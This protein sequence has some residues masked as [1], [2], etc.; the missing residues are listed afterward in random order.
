MRLSAAAC[1]LVAVAAPTLVGVE[2]SF[3]HLRELDDRIRIAAA[4]GLDRLDGQPLSG[5][6][7][8]L[9][10]EKSAEARDLSLLPSSPPDSED[11]RAV[12]TM[13]RA[14]DQ[15]GASDAAAAAPCTEVAAAGRPFEKL[16]AILYACFGAAA[17]AIEVR[18]ERLDRLTALD[19]LAREESPAR[20]KELFLAMEPLYR[21]VNG[22]DGAATSPYRSLIRLSAARWRTGDSPVERSLRA[23]RV[24]SESLEP[25]L[26]SI[27]AAWRDATPAAPIE[28]WDL[29]YAT[30]AADRALASRIPLDR[31]RSISDRFYAA[32]G[33]GPEALG[34]HY[35]LG[36][37]PG[38]T[39]VAFTD[40]GGRPQLRNGRWTTGEPWVF[41]T[42]RTGGLGNL[43][44][45]LHETGHAIHIAAIRTRPAFADWP[46]SDTFTEALADL[47]ALEAFEPEWQ[48]RY[49]GAEAPVAAS[50][51]SKYGGIVLDVAWALFELRLHRDPAADPNAV[52]T[53][54][55]ERYLHVV[56][57]PEISWWARRG[58]LVDSP[59]YMVN[60]ALGAIIVADLRARCRALRGPFSAEDHGY[61]SWLSEKI[62]RYGLERASGGVLREF[63][64]RDMSPE[65]LIA[66]LGRARENLVP[67]PEAP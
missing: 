41:A 4:R 52:W 15:I 50:L 25:W 46:D 58:Q 19:R 47:A 36:P 22:D 21:A 29:A 39:P 37:R 9:S 6:R 51:R 45:L 28:P 55:T 42:Y 14:F 56:P 53:E 40:F 10:E 5:L 26:L 63:L 32:L 65:A 62:Y 44:E 11:A 38:K 16:S 59:G 60:Y 61:Y 54:I 31:L 64:G 23:L 34:I 49:L 3:L 8:R 17:E 30:S 27:L 13:R 48:R 18:G 1:A 20:R 12:A 67:A 66:D 43:V 33:A 7:A 2:R 57:H 35:D 24:P